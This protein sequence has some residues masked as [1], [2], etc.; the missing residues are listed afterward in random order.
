MDECS[1]SDLWLSLVLFLSKGQVPA[2]KNYLAVTLANVSDIPAVLCWMEADCDFIAGFQSISRPARPAHI[3]G[4]FHHNR[5][6]RHDALF[7]PDVKVQ[8]AMR[9][10]PLQ[11]GDCYLG[12][13][14]FRQV[15]ERGSVMRGRWNH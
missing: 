2:L 14:S 13:D 11:A 9:I 15:V 8:R 6:M 4:V 7:I 1:E 3:R 10:L 12:R 5:P